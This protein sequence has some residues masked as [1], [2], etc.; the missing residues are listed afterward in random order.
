MKSQKLKNVTLKL[1]VSK[2][3]YANVIIFKNG[4]IHM[5]CDFNEDGITMDII[6]NQVEKWLELSSILTSTII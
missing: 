5:E 4:R 2:D 3:V 1:F 6:M